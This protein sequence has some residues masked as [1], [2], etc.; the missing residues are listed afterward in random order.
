MTFWL[1]I[2]AFCI[3][4]IGVYAAI[5][6]FANRR[7]R[8]L[9]GPVPASGGVPAL[10][11]ANPT[12]T[13]MTWN[14]GFAG[15]GKDADLIADNGKSLRALGAGD[16]A[17]AA[18][19][20][21]DRLAGTRAD[22]ICLQE[23][24]EAGFLTRGVP[25]RRLIDT[26]LSNRQN[27]YW[28]DMKTVAVPPLLK[29]DHGMSVHSGIDLEQC[30]AETFP[31]DDVY[32]LGVLKKHYGA[33]I[34]RSRIEGS[35]RE[36]V[37]FNVHLSAFDEDGAAR[38]QQFGRLM[39]L[40]TAEYAKQNFVVIAGDWNMRLAPTEFPH[41]AD[42]KQASWM[43]E[44]PVE[45]LPK[46]WQLAVDQGAPSVR[47]LNEPYTAGRNFR[48]IVDGFVHSPNVTL[49]EVRTADLEFELSDHNPVIGYFTKATD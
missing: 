7:T 37:I 34:C 13:V 21:A 5:V 19:K 4:G 2:A 6:V 33:L 44:F 16:I 42:R 23:N 29:I 25:V 48:T 32:H 31:Q 41:Q 20:I 14:I 24:A 30:L 18:E 12:L 38:Q 9:T 15:L 17:L 36:W 3:L 35:D 10:P 39:E 27:H 47:S 28:C 43:I 1:A 49:E 22:V 46:G 40:A 8:P 26:A 11:P 45:M